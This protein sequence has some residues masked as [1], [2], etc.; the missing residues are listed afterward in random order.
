MRKRA[1]RP[2]PTVFALTLLL[3][4]GGATATTGAEDA[5]DGSSLEADL[6]LMME[7]FEGRFDNHWQAREEAELEVEH[8]HGRIHS[9]FAPVEMPELG[10]HVFYVQQYANGNP[11]DIYR[12]RIYSFGVDRDEQAIELLIYAPP[13]PAAVVDAH[14]DPSKLDGLGP[15]NLKS[16]PGCEVYWKRESEDAFIGYTKEGACRVIS[17]RS[18]RELVISD[19][20]RLTAN[21]IWIHDRAVDGDGEYV[22]GHKGGV[23][24]K[25]WK[26]RFFDCWAAAP[27]DADEEE[28]DSWRPLVVHDQGGKVMLDP[29]GG[30]EARYSFE[31]FQA[32]YRG[33]TDVPVFE[34]AVREAGKERSIAYVW[35]EPEAERIGINLRYL[36][37]GCRLQGL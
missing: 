18:G 1:Y 19:D 30:G 27:K 29:P 10:E 5:E 14:L 6:Q 25:L 31:L 15:E 28:W 3:L 33:A 32:I 36:Q 12:Q 22:Y 26:I 17:S 16:Y 23:P 35:T 24:H 37:V 21:E 20:L 2:L 34:L 9:I 8:P 7:W 4:A 11:E 13:D